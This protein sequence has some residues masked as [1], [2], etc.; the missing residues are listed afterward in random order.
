M[1]CDDFSKV[2]FPHSPLILNQKQSKPTN[3]Q[4]LVGFLFSVVFNFFNNS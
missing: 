2:H 4:Y 3:I 1:S